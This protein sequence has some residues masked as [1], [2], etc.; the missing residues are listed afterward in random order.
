M[1]LSDLAFACF[2]YSNL[3]DYDD[4]YMSFLR[5]TNYNPD[6]N[7][8]S[9]R[10]ALLIWLNKWGC[11]QFAVEYHDHVS[12]E[13]EYWYAEFRDRLFDMN[14]NLLNLTDQEIDVSIDAYDALSARI[15]SYRKRN[16]HKF[17][18][19][20]GPTGA[21]KILFAI[22]NKALIPWDDPI[23]QHYSYDGSGVSYRKYLIKSRSILAILN[24]LC[25]K[26]GITLEHL[27]GELNR[28]SSTPL[29]L[30]DEYQWIA[31]TKGIKVP[32]GDNFSKWAR[33]VQ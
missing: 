8:K 4:S 30:I 3:S 19:E 2:M 29:K 5:Y 9:H 27:P 22:R 32:S 7:K 26:N 25:L 20:I 13:I 11:R 31:I 17:P 33:W 23:R 12:A 24:T 18:V 14:R 1:T 6:L 10:K 28:S 15:A 16:R 21:S